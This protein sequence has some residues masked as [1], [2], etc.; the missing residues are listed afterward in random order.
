M[1]ENEPTAPVPTIEEERVEEHASSTDDNLA[2]GQAEDTS[3]HANVDLDKTDLEKTHAEGAS[4]VQAVGEA[5]MEDA[6]ASPTDPSTQP[7]SPP[8]DTPDEPT[9]QP[10]A[11][12]SPAAKPK[13]TAKPSISGRPTASKTAI[14]SP[15]KKAR[16]FIS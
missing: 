6:Q 8:A 2:N 9:K 12:T 3:E 10:S 4:D 16:P 11:P 14:A 5:A 7:S 13:H 1:A 15:V